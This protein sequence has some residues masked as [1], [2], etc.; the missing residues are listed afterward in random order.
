MIFDFGDSDSSSE[1]DWEERAHCDDLTHCDYMYDKAYD[2]DH[3]G[4]MDAGEAAYY[5]DEMERIWN[6]N[7]T[8]SDDDEDD[9][10]SSSYYSDDSDSDDSSDSGY[11]YSS[12]YSGRASYTPRHYNYYYRSSRNPLFND[13]Y[14]YQDP[15]VQIWVTPDGIREI[16]G[17][18][19]TV[20]E[21]PKG[22]NYNDPKPIHLGDI[23]STYKV[24]QSDDYSAFVNY[25]KE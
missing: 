15:P 25:S 8:T 13:S 6:E 11:S 14:K 4:H 22:T 18:V 23:Y 19:L 3:D 12:G 7:S 16:P 20:D 24:D 10:S 5:M 2:L 1:S 9:D 21:R 17:I